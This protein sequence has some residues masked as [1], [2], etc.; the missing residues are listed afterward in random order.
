MDKPKNSKNERL[1]KVSGNSGRGG[2]NLI[3]FASGVVTVLA[4]VGIYLVLFSGGPGQSDL[5]AAVKRLDL[6]AELV[7]STRELDEVTNAGLG[8][9]GSKLKLDEVQ[10]RFDL[11]ASEADE[12]E[13][14]DAIVETATGLGRMTD[15]AH[16]TSELIYRVSDGFGYESSGS[17][18]TRE[19]LD[20]LRKR[21]ERLQGQMENERSR[22]R[23]QM[24]ELED[25][26][27]NDR[28]QSFNSEDEGRSGDDPGTGEDPGSGSLPPGISEVLEDVMDLPEEIEEQAETEIGEESPVLTGPHRCEI[29]SG[30]RTSG[31]VLLN[32][33]SASCEELFEAVDFLNAT[34]GGG[35]FNDAPGW[36]CGR[37]PQT[38]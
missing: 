15:L 28:E 22:L 4:L 27:K 33:G 1:P 19:D 26:I 36:K 5:D 23:A 35:K 9:S 2:R 6:A 37:V 17:G 14:G 31:I 29:D 38:L 21:V 20:A 3:I 10:K 12:V 25:T 8:Q 30:G 13:G 7:D 34:D 16:Q 11:I 24:P 32:S 18:G